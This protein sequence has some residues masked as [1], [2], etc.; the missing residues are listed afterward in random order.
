M[1]I[2]A[3]RPGVGSVFILVGHALVARGL[4]RTLTQIGPVAKPINLLLFL[5]RLR[6]AVIYAIQQVRTPSQSR[7][8]CSGCGLHMI[9]LTMPLQLKRARKKINSSLTLMQRDRRIRVNR[10]AV[11][12]TGPKAG[13]RKKILG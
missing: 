1:K 9:P 10:A 7:S 13:T 6:Q 2:N 3:E 5:G 11:K 8:G 12:K 4:D